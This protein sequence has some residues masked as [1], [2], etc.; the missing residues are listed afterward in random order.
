MGHVVIAPSRPSVLFLC[1]HNAGRSQM[2]AGWLRHLSQ[3]TVDVYS[4]GSS[5]ASDI[6]ERAVAVM[7]EIG[8][9]IGS[10]L[11]KH[12]TDD[13]VRR[14]DV[15]VSMGCG[16]ACPVYRGKR[17]EDWDLPDPAGQPI[18]TVRDIRDEIAGRVRNLLASLGRPIDE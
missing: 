5:P 15:I 16:D 18:D 9:D 13:L 14:A 1:V 17:Y 3:G 4:G 2:A 10:A 12:W 6:N 7:A 8:I 11:P